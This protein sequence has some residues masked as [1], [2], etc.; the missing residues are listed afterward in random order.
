MKKALIIS[1]MVVLALLVLLPVLW[2]ISTSLKPLEEVNKC[3]PEWF[4]PLMSLKPYSDMFFFLPFA[5]YT[6][7]SFIVACSSTVL[8]LLI[9]SLAAFAFSRFS[10]KGKDVFL[11]ILLLSQM[12]PG[13]SVIIPL[14][15]LLQSAGLY[16]TSLGLILVHTAVL[17]PF[18]IWLLYGFFQT[19]PREI[20]DAALIDGC[21]RMEALRKVILPLA[22]PGIGATALFAFLGS[23]NEF[24]FAL[25]LTSSDMT[26]T[27]PVG[28]GLFVGEYTDVWNQMA[29]AAVLFSLPPLILFLFTRKTFV[30]GLVAGA[31]K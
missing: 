28:I 27:I 23:W 22:L 9:G 6:L 26:R 16:D 18:V 7:N 10:F 29:A 11:L 17:L 25:I 21:S 3:P 31:G 19:I 13:A 20:E 30:K 4:C 12:L 5:T 24:F 1:V 2:T 8:T 15:Q 14:F